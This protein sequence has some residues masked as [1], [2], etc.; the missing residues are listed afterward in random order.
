MEIE[1]RL[2]RLIIKEVKNYSK[3]E[4]IEEIEIE[5]PKENLTIKQK[6]LKKLFSSIGIKLKV[7]EGKNIR[8]ISILRRS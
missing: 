7:K 6:T 3:L 2:A 5:I 1:S 4:E 8:I